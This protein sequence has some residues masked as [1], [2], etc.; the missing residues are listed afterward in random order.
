MKGQRVSP[1]RSRTFGKTSGATRRAWAATLPQAALFRPSIRRAASRSAAA[2]L[3]RSWPLSASIWACLLWPFSIRRVRQAAC[4][5]ARRGAR[6]T[7][8]YAT[9]IARAP[10]ASL[11]W[12]RRHFIYHRGVSYLVIPNLASCDPNNDEECRKALA[13][14]QLAGV[15]DDIEPRALAAGRQV[16]APAQGRARPLEK[17]GERS[18]ATPTSPRSEENGPRSYKDEKKAEDEAKVE[19]M[20]NH[21]LFSKAEQALNNRRLGRAGTPR[22]RDL[23]S[24]RGRGPDADPDGAERGR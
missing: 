9:A 13:M 22:H 16:V 17:G 6:F 20:R 2:T 10:G 15:L 1:T 4:R 11:E 14:N 12:V 3:S 7:P 8:P 24:R 23:S 19:L 5:A 18:R 21:G